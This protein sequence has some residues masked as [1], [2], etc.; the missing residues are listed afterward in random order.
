MNLRTRRGVLSDMK[1]PL[2]VWIATLFLGLVTALGSALLGSRTLMIF[3]GPEP[4]GNRLL[5]ALAVS[6]VLAIFSLQVFAL[7]GIVCR[8]RYGRQLGFVALTCLGSCLILGVVNRN[9][10]SVSEAATAVMRAMAAI[11][12]ILVTAFLCSNR[13]HAYFDKSAAA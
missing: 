1:R 12:F 5:V 6:G 2:A 3:F 13:V 4:N 10:E 11:S 9:P 8:W 7:A